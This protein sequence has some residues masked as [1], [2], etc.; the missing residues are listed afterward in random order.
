MKELLAKL[1]EKFFS[2]FRNF[3]ILFLMIVCTA[4]IV[5]LSSVAE[6]S[7]YATLVIKECIEQY[8]DFYDTVGERDAYSSWI[9]W[10]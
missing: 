9:N 3:I 6:H 1:A 7:N 8:H 10:D 2:D 4:L 5:T